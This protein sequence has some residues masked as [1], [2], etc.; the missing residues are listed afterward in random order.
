[1]VSNNNAKLFRTRNAFE[2][3]IGSKDSGGGGDNNL[4]LPV[5][6]WLRRL[7]DTHTTRA[8]AL[9]P[10]SKPQKSRSPSSEVRDYSGLM[11]LSPFSSLHARGQRF[12]TVA[13]ETEQ[14]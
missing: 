5:R 2:R 1:M 3:P 7:N 12:R 6:K 4:S 13:S 8:T 14:K 10:F 11:I 9:A